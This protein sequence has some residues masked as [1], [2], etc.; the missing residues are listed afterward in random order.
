MVDHSLVRGLVRDWETVAE[1]EG[2][3]DPH[4]QYVLNTEGLDTWAFS[5]YGGMKYEGDGFGYPDIG[6]GWQDLNMF[7]ALSVATPRHIAV[8]LVTDTISPDTEGVYQLSASASFNHNSSNNGRI[9][10]FRL[11]DDNAGQPL[12]GGFQVGTGRNTAST[13]V[14]VSILIEITAA[15]VDHQIAIQIGGGDAYSAVEFTSADFSL[16]SVGEYRGNLERKP[17]S[18][19][20]TVFLKDEIGDQLVDELG[21]SLIE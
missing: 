14:G 8:N 10:R 17:P 19:E 15:M 6:A 18:P 9:T 4:T 20:G 1:H 11:Y 12:G 21:N 16:H 7:N 3:S 5:A 2:K 13:S